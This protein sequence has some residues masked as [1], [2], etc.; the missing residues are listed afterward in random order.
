MLKEKRNS[1]LMFNDLCTKRK[2]ASLKKAGCAEKKIHDNFRNIDR[3]SEKM[4]VEQKEVM[5]C[6]Q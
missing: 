4:N 5:I 6:Q 2:N 3:F 1:L